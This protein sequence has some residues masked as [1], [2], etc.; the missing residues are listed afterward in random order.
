MKANQLASWRKQPPTDMESG[1]ISGEF[2]HVI[3]ELFLQWSYL[4][5]PLSVVSA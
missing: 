1:D 5:I 2:G 3:E 4:Q